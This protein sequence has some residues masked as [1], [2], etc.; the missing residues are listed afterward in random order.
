MSVAGICFGVE[1]TNAAFHLHNFAACSRKLVRAPSYGMSDHLAKHHFDLGPGD[2]ELR[3]ALC[4]T[5]RRVWHGAELMLRWLKHPAVAEALGLHR[6]GLRILELGSGSGWLGLNLAAMYTSASVTMSDLPEVLPVLQAQIDRVALTADNGVVAVAF[7]WLAMD[8]AAVM[9]E[10]W[11]L[12]LGSDLLYSHA[13]TRALADVMAALSAPPRAPTMIYAH[14]PGRKASVDASFHDT[15]AG[16]GLGLTPQPRPDQEPADRAEAVAV[17]AD[18]G[19]DEDSMPWLQDGGLFAEE[20]QAYRLSQ[21]GME[22]FD[23]R[24]AAAK[25]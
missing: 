15:F 7:D 14:V 12:V 22:I 21:P 8:E 11:D 19:P 5:H 1:V 13:T 4:T 23:V 2:L 3:K 18:D 20:D 6:P 10:Q 16:A 9:G 17:A 25:V 24:R